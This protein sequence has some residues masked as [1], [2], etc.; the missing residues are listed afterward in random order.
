MI[1]YQNASQFPAAFHRL[2]GLSVT[3]FDALYAEF[4][5]AHTQRIVQ[6]TLT[7]KEAKPRK[8]RQ[9]AGRRF[10][11]TL[12]DRLLLALFWFRIY[13]T[14]AL[15]GRFF[16][17]D[18]TSAEDNLKDVLATL[19]TMFCFTL[20]LPDGRRRKLHTLE[21]VLEAFPDMA[22]VR[23]TQEQ[24]AQKAEKPTPQEGSAG[25]RPER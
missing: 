16:A 17:L 20:E 3:D 4:A 6:S 9:G 21:Q 2:F 19:S 25:M 10:K 12:R 5:V 24:H 11:H 1:T 8:R 15:L 14:L 7:R 23:E 13:P 22:L 18:K